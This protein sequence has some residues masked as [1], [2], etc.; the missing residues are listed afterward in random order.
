[1]GSDVAARKVS[2]PELKTSLQG[3][4]ISPAW[5]AERVGVSMRTVV[6]WFDLD[7]I[8]LRAATELDRI[9]DS[10]VSE[11]HQVLSRSQAS[12]DVL[13]YRTDKDTPDGFPASWHR[14]LTFRVLDH[15][16]AGGGRVS[17]KYIHG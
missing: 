8:P 11:M 15:V 9:L 14:A 10:T 16:K 17:V 6:R 5:F 3:L 1:V 12:G 7:V 13:T 2:G 4:G